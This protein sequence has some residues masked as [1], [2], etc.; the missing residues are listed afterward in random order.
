MRGAAF[1]ETKKE[2]VQIKKHPAKYTDCL[3]PQ[4]D[5]LLGGARIILDPFAGTGKIF[6]LLDFHKYQISAVEIEPEWANHDSRILVGD[7][8]RLPFNDNT[9]EGIVTSPTYGNRMADSFEAKDN[10][11][12]N[13]YRHLLGRRP[14]LNSSSTL[15]WG[16]DYRDFHDKA[17]VE[18]KRVL[19]KKVFLF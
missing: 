7:A 4:I 18:S 19:K 17:W 11:K 16:K 9:F 3:L 12:R 1:M 15:Q 2:M 8:L 10:S 6:K 14:S 13:T 5:K